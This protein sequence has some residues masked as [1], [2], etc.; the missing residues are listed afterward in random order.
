MIKAAAI[1]FNGKVYWVPPP[2]HHQDV[3]KKIV[4]ETEQG[5][6]GA[7][8]GFITNEDVF[9]DRIEAAKIAFDAGQAEELT[10]PSR[11]LAPT[12]LATGCLPAVARSA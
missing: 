3:I 12:L 5:T 1:K 2:G 6:P 10:C 9:V 11:V 7:V 8:H 4:L